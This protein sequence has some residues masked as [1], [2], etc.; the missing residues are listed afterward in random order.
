MKITS[1]EFIPWMIEVGGRRP[2]EEAWAVY[3]DTQLVIRHVKCIAKGTL[4][5]VVIH[6]RDVFRHAIA[7]NA[8]GFIIVH[9]HPSGRLV[10]SQM[11]L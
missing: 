5:A 8:Y 6:P 2:Q 4:D 11:D 7:M 1:D 9:N 10:F 3:V